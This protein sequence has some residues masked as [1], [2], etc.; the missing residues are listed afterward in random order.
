MLRC[1]LT[2]C[3]FGFFMGVVHVLEVIASVLLTSLV[4]S[5]YSTVQILSDARTCVWVYVFCQWNALWVFLCELADTL[6]VMCK[7]GQLP[8]GGECRIKWSRK[9]GFCARCNLRG[10]VSCGK[11]TWVA[12]VKF[13]KVWITPFIHSFIPL[14]CAEC[15]DSLP[16]WGASS[17]P[18]YYIPFSCTLFHQLVFHPPSFH[19]ALQLYRCSPQYAF[20]IF[21]QQT[22]LTIFLK[23]PSAFSYIPPQNVMYFLMLFLLVHKIFT[24][25]KPLDSHHWT[26]LTQI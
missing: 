15:N 9:L 5:E 16:F 18:V 21:S 13:V 2:T 4:C 20:Y 7:F 25:W 6:T 22:H 3:K 1:D 8:K 11:C 10:Y 12:A 26:L 19:L 24:F 23:F 14:A 17:I